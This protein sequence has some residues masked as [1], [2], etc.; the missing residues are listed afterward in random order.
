MIFVYSRKLALAVSRNGQKW[1]QSYIRYQFLSEAELDE[2]KKAYFE[3]SKL[4]HPDLHPNDKVKEQ[5]YIRLSESYELCV[6]FKK[7]NNSRLRAQVTHKRGKSFG[8]G[9]VRI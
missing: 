7:E 5:R 1:A 8:G 3:A 9:K 4:C 6:K 2:I